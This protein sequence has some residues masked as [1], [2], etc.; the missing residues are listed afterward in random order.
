MTNP[1]TITVERLREVLSYD[2]ETGN[3]TYLVGRANVPAGTVTAGYRSGEYL[4]LCIDYERIK[5]H[6]VAWVIVTGE[7]PPMIDHEDTNKL[8]NKWE[9][10]RKATKSQNMMNVGIRSDNKSGARGVSWDSSRKKWTARLR[11]GK[12]YLSLGRFENKEDAIEAYKSAAIKSYGAFARTQ[13]YVH[14]N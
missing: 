6:V 5:A 8:N 4:E 1:K 3:F 11:V 9:N 14:A 12:K 2:P 13:D 10:L 7:W